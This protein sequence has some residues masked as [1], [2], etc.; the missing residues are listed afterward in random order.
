MS[1]FSFSWAADTSKGERETKKKKEKKNLI[2]NKLI[3]AIGMILILNCRLL[4]VGP[5]P[6]ANNNCYGNRKEKSINKYISFLFLV[7]TTI[8]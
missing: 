6:T 1:L 8:C 2:H 5:T 4:L 3:Y 7:T